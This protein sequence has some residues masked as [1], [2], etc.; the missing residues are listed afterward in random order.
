M[1]F[2]ALF[3]F[4]AFWYVWICIRSLVF[5]SDLST[6]P[7]KTFFRMCGTG[8][9]RPLH[10][11][12]DHWVKTRYCSHKSYTKGCH[13]WTR[14][15]LCFF[16]LWRYTSNPTYAASLLRFLDHIQPVWSARRRGRYLHNTQQTQETNIFALSRIRIRDPSNR[17]AP[18]LRP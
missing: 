13:I 8:H 4:L 10:N 9:N 6:S 12:S 2:F 15:A 5:V 7:T 16:L 17:E 1:L 18:N 3:W 14:K 11:Y